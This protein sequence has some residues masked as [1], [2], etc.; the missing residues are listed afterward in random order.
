LRDIVNLLVAN[1]G[2]TGLIEVAGRPLT[3]RAAF[4]HWRRRSPAIEFLAGQTTF[5]P[6]SNMLVILAAWIHRPVHE[7][8]AWPSHWSS[9]I[10]QSR[11]SL[12]WKE[13]LEIL[14]DEKLALV[15]PVADIITVQFDG[16][17][18]S[19]RLD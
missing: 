15:G 12:A 18:R 19:N 3:G 7:S 16:S 5:E 13:V 17:N 6:A 2:L 14:S 11:L 9:F 10:L 4:S 8:P 1:F